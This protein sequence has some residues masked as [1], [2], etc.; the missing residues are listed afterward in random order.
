MSNT[1]H[2]ITGGNVIQI[3]LMSMGAIVPLFGLSGE[4]HLFTYVSVL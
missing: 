4:F 2:K 1:L 3:S